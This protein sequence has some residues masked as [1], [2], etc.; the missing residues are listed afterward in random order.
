MMSNEHTH[1]LSCLSERVVSDEENEESY[2][3][4]ECSETGENMEEWADK[5]T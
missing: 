4:I 5:N 3:I 2:L 1:T